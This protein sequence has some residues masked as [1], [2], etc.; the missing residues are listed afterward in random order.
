MSAAD[1]GDCPYVGE[2]S[3]VPVHGSGLTSIAYITPTD[4]NL[5]PSIVTSGADG[6][7]CLHTTGDFD[8]NTVA[9]TSDKVW[10]TASV[11]AFHISHG[12]AVGE[13]QN[14]KVS[15]CEALESSR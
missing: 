15:P 5:E 13:C 3:V 11:V 1:I 12:V 8:Q 4:S 14:V 9:F 6:R 2:I 7:V 10:G